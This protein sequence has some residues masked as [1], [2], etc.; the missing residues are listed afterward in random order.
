MRE[1]NNMS[2]TNLPGLP[3]LQPGTI[4]CIGKN[5][6]AHA[7]EMNSTIPDQP[8]VFIKPLTSLTLDGI[9][10]IPAFVAEPHYEAELVVAIGK[11]GKNIARESALDHVAGYGLGIDVTARDIQ[12]KLIKAAHP[13]FLAKGMDTFAPVSPFISADSVDDPQQLTFTLTINGE[14]RQTGDTSLMLF[15]VSEL[16]A[17]LSRYVTLFPGDLI[18][19]GTPEGVGLLQN[20]DKLQADLQSGRTVLKAR[21]EITN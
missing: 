5:Y 15:P 1:I 12:H 19:T 21:V 2:H 3:G 11:K 20:G 10:R 9:I 18:F 4:Y 8:V 14:K 17:T 13:W 16:I 6:A 7:R